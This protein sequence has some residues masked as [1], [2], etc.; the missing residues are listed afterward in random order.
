MQIIFYVSFF[1]FVI[2]WA[3]K[4]YYPEVFGVWFVQLPSIILSMLLLGLG[5][6]KS[7]CLLPSLKGTMLSRLIVP[8]KFLIVFA[9]FLGVSSSG[10][11]LLGYAGVTLWEL[12]PYS[13]SDAKKL[14]TALYSDKFEGKEYVARAI[15]TQYGA[16]VSYDSADGP[17]I[18]NPSK[19]DEILYKESQST[20]EKIAY[21][22]SKLKRSIVETTFAV[23]GGLLSFVM[24]F[25]LALCR[26]LKLTNKD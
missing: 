25:F 23:I 16:V 21:T 15:Y 11:G 1:L 4:Q 24:G 5:F 12:D 9:F 2:P 7:I 8:A 26:E 20:I 6:A 22:K 17:I 13:E 10:L 19:D 14:I 18:F 3:G